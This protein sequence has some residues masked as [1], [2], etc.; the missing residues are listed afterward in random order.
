[1]PAMDMRA[2]CVGAQ[3]PYRLPAQGKSSVLQEHAKPLIA[4]LL[5]SCGWIFKADQALVV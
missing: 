1:M 5:K 2:Q 4:V 3:A